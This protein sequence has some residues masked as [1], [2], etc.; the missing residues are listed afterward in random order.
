M[1]IISMLH[2]TENE[3]EKKEEQIMYNQLKDM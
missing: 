2:S 3:R 1:R